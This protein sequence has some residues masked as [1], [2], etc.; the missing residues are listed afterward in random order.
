MKRKR[1]GVNANNTQGDETEG[2]RLHYESA[3]LPTE[4]RRLEF[5]FPQFTKSFANE[6]GGWLTLV[7]YADTIITGGCP[8]I[9]DF[10]SVGTTNLDS[11]VQGSHHW[12]VDQALGDEIKLERHPQI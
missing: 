1:R 6:S 8:T 4:L 10:R 11:N 7:F 2:A 12:R 5:D 9:R 3:A